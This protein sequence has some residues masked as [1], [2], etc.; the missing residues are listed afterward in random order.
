MSKKEQNIYQLPY[1]VQREYHKLMNSK[2]SFLKKHSHA[3]LRKLETLYARLQDV[4]N[5]NRIENLKMDLEKKSQELREIQNQIGQGLQSYEQIVE[6][7]L[8]EDLNLKTKALTNRIETFQLKKS[9]LRLQVKNWKEDLQEREKR[10][11]IKISDSKL[12]EQEKE[13]ILKEEKEKYIKREK[14]LSKTLLKRENEELEILNLLKLDSEKI[15]TEYKEKLDNFTLESRITST[16]ELPYQQDLESLNETHQEK[17]KKMR[18]EKSERLKQF[19]EQQQTNLESLKNLR[20][21]LEKSLKDYEA[22]L[23]GQLRQEMS[24]EIVNCQ[25]ELVSYFRQGD[26]F[27]I[28]K[29]TTSLLNETEKLGTALGRELTKIGMTKEEYFR[30]FDKNKKK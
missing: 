23:V 20:T 3:E 17:M 24:E 19:Q 9:D 2:E 12:M 30:K 14:E 15:M 6:A 27:S 22:N 10:L 7:E 28:T 26:E 5:Q 4:W 21:E 25:E 13:L 11:L 29:K 18:A 1:E 8:K 16:Q